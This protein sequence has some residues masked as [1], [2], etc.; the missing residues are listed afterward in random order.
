MKNILKIIGEVIVGIGFL[1][2]LVAAYI[3]SI[4][5]AITIGILVVV[6][7]FSFEEIKKELSPIKNALCE[8][9]KYLAKKWKFVPMHEIQPVGYVQTFSPVQLTPIGIDLLEKSGA[10]KLVDDKYNDWKSV[11]S[12]NSLKTAYDVQEHASEIIAEKENDPLMAPLKGYVYK[13]P[14]L[15]KKPLGLSDIQRCMVV[16]LRDLFL[17]EHPEIVND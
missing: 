16:Y 14:M 2:G 4:E 7:M 10:K 9:Q 12:K 6:F 15:N 17:K 1:Y 8:M 13:N 11:L 5:I 3:I